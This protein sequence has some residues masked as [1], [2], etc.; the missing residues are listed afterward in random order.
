MAAAEGEAEIKE[1]E[2]E[3]RPKGKSNCIVCNFWKFV[4]ITARI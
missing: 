3:E 4:E 2:E 1:V